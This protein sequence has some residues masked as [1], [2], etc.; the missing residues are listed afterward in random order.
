[1]LNFD[2]KQT[3]QTKHF[4]KTEKFHI[5]KILHEYKSYGRKH[6]ANIL[7]WLELLHAWEVIGSNFSP[8]TSYPDNV[9][10]VFSVPP[11]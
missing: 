9:F 7:L 3:K 6:Q 1:M 11:A 8:G 5:Q 4:R 10:C 2:R